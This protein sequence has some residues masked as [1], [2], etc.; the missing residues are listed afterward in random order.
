MTVQTKVLVVDEE[1][2]VRGTFQAY[3]EKGGYRVFTA[4]G[5]QEGLEAFDREH[6][7][8]VLSGIRMAATD[9]L[10]FL[11]TVHLQ[12]PETAVVAVSAPDALQKVLEGARLGAWDYLALPLRDEGELDVV[13]GRALERVGLVAENRGCRANLEALADQRSRELREGMERTAQLESANEE[14]S[15]LNDDLVRRSLDLEKANQQLESFSYSISHDLRT[16]LRHVHVFSRMLLEGYSG[17]LDENGNRCLGFIESGC[18]RMECLVE[19][20]LSFC[21][22]SLQPLVKTTVQTEALVKD[23]LYE[24]IGD[25]PEKRVDVVIGALPACQ[26]DIPLLRQV[27]VNLLGN[28]LKYSRNRD[29]PRIEAGS[30]ESNGETVFFVRDNGAGFNMEF[31]GKLFGVFQRL[32]HSDEYEGTGVGLAVAYNIIQRHNGKIWA[33]AIEDRGA[34]FYFTLARERF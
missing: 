3:L 32:Q 28:A 9:G 6:P 25:S 33:E 11:D 14:I 16:P 17:K 30:F 29:L 13:I 19:D 5:S 26:A 21:K 7:D 15:T 22:L 18:K 8:V 31:A 2:Q 23:V 20:L 24:L 34:T 27:F 10:K 12:C 1:E 4:R